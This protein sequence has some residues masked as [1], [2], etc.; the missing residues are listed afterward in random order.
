MMGEKF[1]IGRPSKDVVDYLKNRKLKTSFHWSEIWQHEHAAA[2]TVAK[3]TQRD[4]LD[5]FHESL[6]DSHAKGKTLVQWQREITPQL[7]QKNWWGKKKRKDPATGQLTT[8]QLGSKRRLKTIYQT[9]MRTARAAGQWK[10]IQR[11]KKIFPYLVYGLGPSIK[12]RAEHVARDGFAAPID[13][14]IWNSWY[15][16]NG[17]HCKCNVRQV[18]K[19]EAANYNQNP[20]QAKIVEW[21]N[22]RTGEIKKLPKGIDAGFN[23]N[24]GKARMDWLNSRADAKNLKAIYDSKVANIPAIFSTNTNIDAYVLK[25]AIANIPMA[26]KRADKA[27]KFIHKNNIKTILIDDI[28]MNARTKASKNIYNDIM[29]Y[30]PAKQKKYGR[31]NYTAAHHQ[32]LSGFTAK[33]FNHVVIKT[34]KSVVLTMDAGKNLPNNIKKTIRA[35]NNNKRVSS[36]LANL[37]K[38]EQV[39]VAYMHE[40]GHQL[41]FK[42]GM[43]KV[44]KGVKKITKYI[45]TD[46]KYEWFA[47]SFVA[48]LTN[49]DEYVKFDSIGAKFFDDLIEQVLKD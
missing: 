34:D 19:E 38:T 10:R 24:V 46:Q 26:R 17:W 2:F 16:P 3:A 48:W 27:V 6:I 4:V 11:N 18:T 21:I 37:N 41:H 35:Y 7:K 42:A 20:P 13:D 29:A 15:P 40:L 36:T 12:H 25:E 23:Y 32:S 9:N 45:D 28:E 49:Y 8:V 43:P 5:L 39:L 33:E 31:Y 14:P 30:L 22:P 47:E 1:N 44:P